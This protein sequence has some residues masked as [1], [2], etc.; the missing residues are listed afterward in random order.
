MAESLAHK[1]GQMIG[2]I[3]EQALAPRLR[4]IAKK[5][6]LYLDSKGERSARAGLKVSWSDGRKNSHDLDF[7]LERGGTEKK[8]GEPVAFIESA[9]RRY[10]KHSRNKAQEIQGALIPLSEKYY[11]NSPTLC[12]LLAGEWTKGAKN[13]LES[14]N[15]I[16]LH[17]NYDNIVNAF[18]SV[19]VDVS[20]NEKTSEAEFQDKVQQL[21]GIQKIEKVYKHLLHSHSNEIEAFF[22]KLQVSIQKQISYILINSLYGK[23]TQIDSVGDAITFI[24]E[25]IKDIKG[26]KF[27]SFI[28]I[29]QYKNGNQVE[30]KFGDK[31]SAV[32]FLSKFK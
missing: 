21:A 18:K 10:T 26:I 5:N 31:D 12:A 4:E 19:G 13:Q 14:N 29:V 17:F 28:I 11:Y 23:K 22:G 25:S 2:D 9:W 27:D 30:G 16:V 8:I 1:L 32:D 6:N 7:V 24:K 20:T 3:I 15:F